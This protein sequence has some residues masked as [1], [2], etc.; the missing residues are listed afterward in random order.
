MD[1][2]TATIVSALVAGAVAATTEVAAQAIKDAYAG[3]KAL[4]IRKLGQR[5]KVEDALNGVEARPESEGR[6]TVLGEELEIA[7]A[8]DD[9]EVVEEAKALLELLKEHGEESGVSYHAQVRGSGAVAQGPGAVAAG[10]R[11]VAIGGSVQG[12]TITTGGG[13]KPDK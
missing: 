7:K 1:P 2:I 11:G 4:V 3:L 5:A 12:S 9:A 10:E 6:K 13:Q 8:S